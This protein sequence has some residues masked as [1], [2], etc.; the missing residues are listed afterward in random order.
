MRD[1]SNL[2]IPGYLSDTHPGPQH[3]L[4]CVPGDHPE[5][6]LRLHKPP[7]STCA[8]EVRSSA[9]S[10]DP[11]VPE[12]WALWQFTEVEA[13]RRFGLII[14]FAVANRIVASSPFGGPWPAEKEG[15]VRACVAALPRWS[16]WLYAHQTLWL[17]P[18]P[19][20]D[21]EK[22]AE[23]L[24]MCASTWCAR[25]PGDRDPGGRAATRPSS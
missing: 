2:E 4:Y 11:K 24:E 7:I 10:V 12:T 18:G 5:H 9:A 14:S 8:S 22:V 19:D 15:P 1:A 25:H 3:L 23:F 21:E 6:P 17:D 20:W 16:G 13:S